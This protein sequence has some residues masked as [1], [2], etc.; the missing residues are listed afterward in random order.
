MTQDQTQRFKKQFEKAEEISPA[1]EIWHQFADQGNFGKH[2]RVYKMLFY[3]MLETA[4]PECRGKASSGDIGYS[5][6]PIN[7]V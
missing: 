6:K 2:K 3:A 5:L 7:N 4:F 1:H